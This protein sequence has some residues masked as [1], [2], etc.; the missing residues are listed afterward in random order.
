MRSEREENDG[1]GMGEKE[2]GLSW[3]FVM[4]D[5]GNE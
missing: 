5:E 1:E 2:E 3:L 4:Y